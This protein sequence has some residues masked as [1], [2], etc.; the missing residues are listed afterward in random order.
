[1]SDIYSAPSLPGRQVKKEAPAKWA[2][3]NTILQSIIQQLEAEDR[4]AIVLRCDELPLLRGSEEEIEI[5]FSGLLQMILQIKHS[6]TQ[7][8]LHI[9]YK[10]DEQ[11]SLNNSGR[12]QYTIQFNTN[13]SPCADWMQL[14]GQQLTGIAAIVQELNGSLA[15]GEAQGCLFSLSFP[16]KPL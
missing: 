9:N 1:M 16:G 4:K 13:I 8:F 2:N 12:K 5:I 15:V 6:V 3:A 11:D 10:T 14:N 7:L